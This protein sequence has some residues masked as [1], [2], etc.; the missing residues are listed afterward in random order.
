MDNPE[1]EEKLRIGVIEI[2]QKML[3]GAEPDYR[4]DAGYVKWGVVERDIGRKIR[5]IIRREDKCT[6]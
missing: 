1:L 6:E 3:S 5:K 2:L 4:N